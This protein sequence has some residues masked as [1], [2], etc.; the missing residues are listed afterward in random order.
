MA[1]SDPNR[2]RTKVEPVNEINDKVFELFHVVPRDR[3]G[4]INEEHNVDSL[5]TSTSCWDCDCWGLS[6][7]GARDKIEGSAIFEGKAADSTSGS[8][9][10]GFERVDI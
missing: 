5:T 2:V 10:I 1:H 4:S 8:S 9:D 6:F 3:K 7:K